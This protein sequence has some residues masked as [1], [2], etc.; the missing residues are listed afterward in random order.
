MNAAGSTLRLTLGCLLGDRLGIQ[1]RRVGSGNRLTFTH[2]G[3]AALSHW[4]AA[5]A[6]V[7][8]AETPEPWL[9]EERALA[10]LDLPLNL[11]TN[12][13][14]AFRP[15]LVAVRAAAR[16]RARTLPITT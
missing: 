11:H 12:G 6:F 3:E 16:T 2:D 9:W 4:M 8:W 1:L 7:A 13:H 15:I 10:L 5:H 14:H